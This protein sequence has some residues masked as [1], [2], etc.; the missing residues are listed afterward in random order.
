M[1]HYN[2]RKVSLRFYQEVKN[3]HYNEA[4]LLS[5]VWYNYHI[6]S[7]LTFQSPNLRKS[8]LFFFLW[9]AIIALFRVVSEVFI[10]ALILAII[11][12]S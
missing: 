6:I 1:P 12:T 3:A 7:F 9:Y 8:A 11:Q 4:R 10:L 2:A 5:F